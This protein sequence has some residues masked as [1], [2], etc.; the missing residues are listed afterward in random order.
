[1]LFNV[2]RM[3]FLTT[4]AA[5]KGV[6]AIAQY[7][8]PAG[9]LITLVCTAGL[10]GLALT[11]N[12]KRKTEIPKLKPEIGSRKSV[13]PWSVVGCPQFL[14]SFQHFSISVFRIFV[15]LV[16]FPFSSPSS[17]GLLPWRSV[18][19]FGIA[20]WNRIWRPAQAGRS[21][22]PPI[23]QPSGPSR[24]TRRRSACCASMRASR[25]RGNR[26]RWLQVAGLLL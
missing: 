1:M 25:E 19:N 5:K 21:C 6:A 14:V 17:S 7:H 13:V 4:I 24:W 18:S 3:T 11:F 23:T 9:I 20:T 12:Q 26:F 2:C 16:C 22:F 15:P 8:D 10:W